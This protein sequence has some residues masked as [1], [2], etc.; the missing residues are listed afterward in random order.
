MSQQWYDPSSKWLL[1]EHR[2]SI[3]YLAGARSV[4]SCRARKAEVV[5]PRKL[6]DGALLLFGRLKRNAHA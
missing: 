1:E 2:A 6:P 5:Q 3:L 4:T